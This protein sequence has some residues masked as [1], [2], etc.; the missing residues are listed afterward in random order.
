MMIRSVSSFTALALI[1]CSTPALRPIPE[2][3]ESIIQRMAALVQEIDQYDW[4]VINDWNTGET[5]MDKGYKIVG[6]YVRGRGLRT[7]AIGMGRAHGMW[8]GA[9][10]GPNLHQLIFTPQHVS[11]SFSVLSMEAGL[12]TESLPHILVR[13]QN[14]D[15]DHRAIDPRLLPGTD[16]ILYRWDEPLMAYQLAPELMLGHEPNLVLEGI[17]SFGLRP[18]WLL[19][20]RRVSD[21]AVLGGPAG[22]YIARAVVKRFYIEIRT[23]LLAGMEWIITL[24]ADTVMLTAEVSGRQE[25]RNVSLPSHVKVTEKRGD[26]ILRVGR[27]RLLHHG[28]DT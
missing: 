21:A 5:A 16:P 11:A 9:P 24:D 19:E 2:T 10:S 17:V 12:N 23:G 6:R 22:W 7:K 26:R 13:A 4:E 8:H 3:P 25:Y 1:S 28:C 14:G 27:R 18:C 15:P 20:S